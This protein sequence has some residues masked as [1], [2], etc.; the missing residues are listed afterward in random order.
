MIETLIIIILG[1]ISF[2]L[3]MLCLSILAN[4]ILELKDIFK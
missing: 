4:I 1:I 2:G 3:T